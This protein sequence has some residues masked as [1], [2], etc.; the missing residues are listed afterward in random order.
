MLFER[1]ISKIFI[2]FQ[3]F[4]EHEKLCYLNEFLMKHFILFEQ[5]SKHEQL[6]YSNEF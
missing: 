3:R 4:Y 6:C 5:F 2:L 1:I